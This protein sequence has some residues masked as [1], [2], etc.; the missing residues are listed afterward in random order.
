MFSAIYPMSDKNFI[1]FK[2]QSG[3][4]EKNVLCSIDGMKRGGYSI[5]TKL[6]GKK[7]VSSS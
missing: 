5:S 6:S 4:D 3:G 7:F 1:G 2:A